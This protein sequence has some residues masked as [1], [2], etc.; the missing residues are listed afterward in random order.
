MDKGITLY[1]SRTPIFRFGGRVLA[2]ATVI[3][4]DATWA[5]CDAN[6]IPESSTQGIKLDLKNF[7]QNEV[8]VNKSQYPKGLVVIWTI[9]ADNYAIMTLL[10][11]PR[12]VTQVVVSRTDHPN[13]VVV[14]FTR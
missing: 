8:T 5:D 1:Y 10:E 2:T 3:P 13:G 7:T 11:F 4:K 14:L 9:P 12:E 6:V